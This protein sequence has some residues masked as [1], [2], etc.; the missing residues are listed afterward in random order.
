[1]VDRLAQNE[2]SLTW[3]SWQNYHDPVMN[4]SGIR[5]WV[6][7]WFRMVLIT[8]SRTQ[9]TVSFASLSPANEAVGR[10]CFQSRVSVSLCVQRGREVPCDHYPR[11][12]GPHHLGTPSLTGPHSYMAP[13]FPASDIWWPRLETCSNLFTWGLPH[14]CWHLMAG[15][16]RGAGGMHHTGM[17]SC[18]P[19]VRRVLNFK[20]TVLDTY[21]VVFSLQQNNSYPLSKS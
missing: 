12:I 17:F 14:Q 20:R 8:G 7:V 5:N 13:A 3:W 15:Y 11:C 6:M 9:R 2:V 4:R 21:L 10:E 16:W 1:M 18:F 19:F